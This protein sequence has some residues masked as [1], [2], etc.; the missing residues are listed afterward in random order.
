M[1]G[2]QEGGARMG[3]NVFPAAHS[4]GQAHS[5]DSVHFYLIKF[6]KKIIFSINL[7]AQRIPQYLMAK[8]SINGKRSGTFEN[9][10]NC[11]ER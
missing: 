6:R 3:R 10:K 11:L 9:V 7:A 5:T 4:M 8:I 2:E 1:A